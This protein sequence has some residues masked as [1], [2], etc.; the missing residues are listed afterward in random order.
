MCEDVRFDIVLTDLSLRLHLR[1]EQNVWRSGLDGA[2][3]SAR[4]DMREF[5]L[6]QSLACRFD[7]FLDDVIQTEVQPNT[8]CEGSENQ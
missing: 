8:F 2:A 5:V 1:I 3:G 4:V 6:L 7:A